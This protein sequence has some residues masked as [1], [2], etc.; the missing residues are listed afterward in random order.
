MGL[1]GWGVAGL[2][3]FVALPIVQSALVYYLET[4]LLE[5][6]GAVGALRRSIYLAL[7]NPGIALMGAVSWWVLLVWFAVVAEAGGQAI[8]DFILQLGT[9]FGDARNGVVTPYM[10]AGLLLAHPIHAVYRLLLYV[11]V[12]TR[13]EGW[14]VQV[15]LRAVGLTS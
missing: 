2:T 13:V 4:T 15:A 14:D 8:V 6:V 3:C 12:R 7:G 1:L 5:Q 11:D 9:P 10:L